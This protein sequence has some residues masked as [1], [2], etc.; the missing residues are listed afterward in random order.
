MYINEKVKQKYC[1]ACETI[2]DK[3]RKKYRTPSKCIGYLDFDNSL[4]PNGYLSR[5][6][7]LE[8]SNY[9]ALSDYERLIIN[10]V[11]N[12]YGEEV[13]NKAVKTSINLLSEDKITMKG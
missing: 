11:I 3:D 9:L 8:S 6:F 7:S 1:Y 12:K 2:W 5:L 4:I 13:R 10:T